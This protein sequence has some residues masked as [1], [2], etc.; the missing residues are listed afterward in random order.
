MYSRT[1][2]SNYFLFFFLQTRV[3]F[4]YQP[5]I[6]LKSIFYSSTRAP[7]Q[8]DGHRG[9]EEC[10]TFTLLIIYK[11]GTSYIARI[12]ETKAIGSF[13]PSWYADFILI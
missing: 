3:L 5:P 7:T 6:L 13:K 1:F 8:I 2:L 11:N 9:F 4:Q 12:Q 10:K